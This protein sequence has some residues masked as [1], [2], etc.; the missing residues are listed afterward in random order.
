MMVELEELQQSARRV[1]HDLGLAATED[2]VWP[3]IIE[4]D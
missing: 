2:V 1:M 4:L 3:Q